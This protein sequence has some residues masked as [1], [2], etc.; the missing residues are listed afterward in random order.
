MI[1]ENRITPT[2]ERRLTRAIEKAATLSSINESLDRN[3]VLINALKEENVDKRFAKAASAAFNKRITVLTFKKTADEHKAE[4]FALTDA[5]IVY[6]GLGGTIHNKTASETRAFDVTLVS[7]QMKKAA[8]AE[9]TPARI[10]YEERVDYHTY[11]NHLEAMIDKHAAAVSEMS[12]FLESLDS[13]IKEETQELADHFQKSACSSFEFTTL[14]NRY[15]DTFI[16][17]IKDFLPKTT[18][19][20]KTAS[21]AIL[22]KGGVYD[23]TAVLLQKK[24]AYNDILGF[25]QDYCKG[26]YEFC[27]SAG[28]ESAFI[29][30]AEYAGL[31]KRASVDLGAMPGNILRGGALTGMVLMQGA[32]NV[33][34]ATSDALAKGFSNAQVMY[35]AGGQPGTAPSEIL[36]SEFL[37][38]DRFRDR[39]MAWSDMSADP[40]FSM[41][42]AEQVFQATHKAMNMDT[43][44][45]RP[46]RRELLRAQV[47]QLL[48]QN[49]RASTADL[50]ALATTLKGLSAS[51]ASAPIIAAAPI[52]EREKTTAPELPVLESM[53]PAETRDNSAAIDR[54]SRGM[55]TAVAEATKEREKAEAERKEKAKED[56]Q[57]AESIDKGIAD[58]ARDAAQRQ[59][60]LEREQRQ[61]Q[62]QRE[63]EQ[64][65]EERRKQL[66]EEQE[67][68]RKEEEAARE[69]KRKQ[70]QAELAAAK[71]KAE[72]DASAAG[73]HNTAV[74]KILTD[75]HIQYDPYTKTFTRPDP[76][77]P[78]NMIPVSRAQVLNWVEAEK[79]RRSVLRVDK[80]NPNSPK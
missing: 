18:D 3:Q 11:Q 77:D 46:D 28:K 53:L 45:E 44:L 16:D 65:A 9:K 80:H 78:S 69:T 13:Q 61:Q 29:E 70:E 76:S 37:I 43:A 72:R 63:A 21:A 6:Q 32:E 36:D 49:N 4:P 19:F 59:E 2:E 57:I 55:E 35:N 64:R 25:F 34:K 52:V 22:P 26:V 5:D 12:G 31:G 68:K 58:K 38:K 66:A 23:K 15:G 56:K 30:A 47:G 73:L 33:R 62:R 39:M 7:P 27:K 24:A 10:P 74:T 42:P 51:T 41:Y 54:L 79:D 75:Y 14:I 60:Q 50:A 1:M 40:Q 20:S 71:E 17:A 48:A 67:K 8:S